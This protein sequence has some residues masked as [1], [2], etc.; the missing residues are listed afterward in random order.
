MTDARS[1]ARELATLLRR[2]QAATAEFLAALA[3]FDERRCWEDLGYTS[4]FYFLHRELRLSK[5]AAFY[6]SQA[7]VLVR[8]HPEVLDALRDGQ[9]CLSSVAELAKVLTPDNQAEVL[10]RFFHAS[11]REA[12]VVVAELRPAARLPQRDVMTVRPDTADVRGIP[13]SE[14][15]SASAMPSPLG[16]APA[17]VSPSPDAAPPLAAGVAQDTAFAAVVAAV[18]TPGSAR[19][20]PRTFQPDEVQPLTGDLRRLHVTVSRRVVDKLTAARDALSHAL[21]DASTADVLERALDAFLLADARKRK[22][23][24]DRPRPRGPAASVPASDPVGEGGRASATPDTRTSRHVP[25]EVKRAVWAR[26]E[27]RCQFTLANGGICGSTRWLEIDHVVPVA[28]GGPSTV[29][30][31]RLLCGL[32]NQLAA[33]RTFGAGWMRHRVEARRGSSVQTLE[34]SSAPHVPGIV[35]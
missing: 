10:P 22:A 28:R 1:F 27:A 23:A 12:K 26:D 13:G 14:V 35:L 18:P 21:P 9:L 6:R 19:A 32:H 4:L 30:N 31:T 33:R 2:E 3:R 7:A 5:G 11:S 29:E 25:A 15:E 16:L 8:R 17:F 24:A 20:A 34:P